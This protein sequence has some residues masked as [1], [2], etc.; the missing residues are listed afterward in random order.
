MIALNWRMY[1]RR[2]FSVSLVMRKTYRIP[3]VFTS[4]GYKPTLRFSSSTFQIPV[5]PALI[6]SCLRR[7]VLDLVRQRVGVHRAIVEPRRDGAVV[8]P[9]QGVL[10]PVRIVALGEILAGMGAA[11]FLAGHRA[12]DGDDGLGDEVV[13]FQG[14]DQIGVPDHR[15]V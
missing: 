13:I 6:R 5:E 10:H 8:V 11:A 7:D 4:D 12:F 15:A 3:Q 2:R 9:G 1:S 14:L